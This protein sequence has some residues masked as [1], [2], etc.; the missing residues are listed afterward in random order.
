MFGISIRNGLLTA[1]IVT[2]LLAAGAGYSAVTGIGNV[3]AGAREISQHN[4]PS[5]TGALKI[6]IALGSLAAY[7]GELLAA[8]DPIK[9]SELVKSI[10][11][12]KASI[13]E[14]SSAYKTKIPPNAT[15]EHADFELL[16]ADLSKYLAHYATFLGYANQN[17][18]VE[19]ATLLLGDLLSAQHAV[20]EK[21]DMLV[22]LNET[23]AANVS[24]NNEKFYQETFFVVSVTIAMQVGLSLALLAYA[25]W[26]VV[27][28]IGRITKAMT[29]LTKGNKSITVPFAGQKTELGTMA[30]AV[31]VFKDNMIE[32]DR[33]RAEQDLA[34][35][36]QEQARIRGEAE[37]KRA[38]QELANQFE[39]TVG[40]VVGSVSTAAVEMQATAEALSRTANDAS[41]KSVAVA[42]VVEDVTRN[43]HGVAAATEEL[44][45]SIREISG[46]AGE[47]S[48]IVAE[49][50]READQTA[51]QMQALA[52]SAVNIGNVVKLI[53]EI[54]N[55][56]NLLAL[57]A[58]IEAARAGE[59][60]RGFAVVAT[61]VKSLASQTAKATEEIAAQISG[62]QE[63]TTSSV[64][65]IGHIRST[66]DRM[67]HVA[68]AIAA[69]VEQ[70]GAATL[71]ISRNVQHASG[72]ATEASSSID[73]V[74]RASE[75]TSLSSGE[76]L[77][78]A[79]ELAR[80]GETLRTQVDRFLRE[81][82]AA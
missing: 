55:Q 42:S 68:T 1:S 47:S 50:V 17:Q 36:D 49:A 35:A 67:S 41:N 30:G 75:E 20:N 39:R 33:L 34:R 58:T 27:K 61:E 82:R 24:E 19:A 8:N 7:A 18:D 56:T 3:K 46:Q 23:A 43:M 73:G 22:K 38:M 12:A 63:A 79:S 70:Q 72:G 45:A 11:R 4:L 26:G 5:M 15:E 74:T 6:D 2:I 81:V 77:T 51:N 62:M 66:I 65:A 64:S 78:A 31:Q 25:M 21:V 52:E 69:A 32:T 37:R 29:D 13:R 10:E 60:G 53:N 59:S 80:N 76:V 44:S 40:D 14:L 9:I 16:Q 28:P 54:A 57:N 71:E 48:R